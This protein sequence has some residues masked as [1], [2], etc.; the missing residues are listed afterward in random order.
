MRN[1]RMVGPLLAL[2]LALAACSG[3]AA[4]TAPATTAPT[5]PAAATPVPTTAAVA[6][7]APAAAPAAS[8]AGT[9]RYGGGGGTPAPGGAL[10]IDLATTGLGKVLA[11][12]SGMTL[13]V[14]LADSGGKS[15]CSGSCATNWPPLTGAK[16]KV[17]AGLDDSDFGSITR[18]DGAKQVTFYGRPLYYFAGDSAAGQANGQ[19]IGGKWYVVG[20]DGKPIK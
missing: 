17:G 6:S 1:L 16:P 20:T 3:A 10:T 12:G 19:G 18:S 15:A 4:T 13:Y 9:D 11:D 5:T 14:F 8:S 2:G 7:T